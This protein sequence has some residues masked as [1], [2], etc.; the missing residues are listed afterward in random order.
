MPAT[1]KATR[2]TDTTLTPTSTNHQEKTQKTINRTDSGEASFA[3][4]RNPQPSSPGCPCANKAEATHTPR[5]GTCGC[6]G[7]GRRE[8]LSLSPEL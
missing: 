3:K 5:P 1:F 8:R 6:S 7:E 4:T 2:H